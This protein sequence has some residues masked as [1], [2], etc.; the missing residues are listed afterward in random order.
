MSKWLVSDRKT[1]YFGNPRLFLIFKQLFYLFT[2]KAKTSI[3]EKGNAYLWNYIF[4]KKYCFET[5]YQFLEN[6]TWLIRN[7]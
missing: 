5:Y 2:K 1:D 7:K 3:F 4:L 6:V